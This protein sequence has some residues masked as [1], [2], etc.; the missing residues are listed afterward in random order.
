[1]RLITGL[2]G[3]NGATNENML[4]L[5]STTKFVSPVILDK[6]VLKQLMA[7]FV[8][9]L[10]SS[11]TKSY[12]ELGGFENNSSVAT[13]LKPKKSRKINR[14]FFE[15]GRGG[16]GENQATND[17]IVYLQSLRIPMA[18]HFCSRQY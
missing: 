2:L 3:E 5:L 8:T 4:S 7:F 10:L 12:G 13:N 17:Q 6:H 15:R 18:R 1:M 14:T 16:W 11:V 9:R